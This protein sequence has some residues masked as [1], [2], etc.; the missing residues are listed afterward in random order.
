M[1]ADKEELYWE[2]RARAN[3]LKFGDRNTPFFHNHASSRKRMNSISGL[4]DSEGVWKSDNADL[5]VMA[6]NYFQELFQSSSP[7]DATPI[8]RTFNLELLRF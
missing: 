5:L 1:E 4:Y 2:Q 8:T 3:W 7:T 6:S